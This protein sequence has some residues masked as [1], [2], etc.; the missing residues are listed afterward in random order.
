MN[1]FD[2]QKTNWN[3]IKSRHYILHT[4]KSNTIFDF[5][6]NLI[7]LCNVIGQNFHLK[8]AHTSVSS[9]CEFNERRRRARA[10]CIQSEWSILTFVHIVCVCCTTIDCVQRTV[11]GKS[12]KTAVKLRYLHI[13]NIGQIDWL[14]GIWNC[15]KTI[16]F[17]CISFQFCCIVLLLGGFCFTLCVFSAFF[18]N[19]FFS[20]F[21]YYLFTVHKIWL[22]SLIE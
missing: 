5:K 13:L 15:S 17:E 12:E 18:V 22:Y 1:I 16:E 7:G 20:F 8:P 4:H 19:F 3:S 2:V 14:Q 21:K 11:N 10:V 6:V 9:H